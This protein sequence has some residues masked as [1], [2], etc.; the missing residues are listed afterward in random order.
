MIEKI[1]QYK[2]NQSGAYVQTDVFW[3]EQ[4]QGGKKRFDDIGA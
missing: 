4:G 3:V 1:G 2:I